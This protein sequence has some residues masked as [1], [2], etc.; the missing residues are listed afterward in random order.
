MK[1]IKYKKKKT[2]ASHFFFLLFIIHILT[3]VYTFTSLSTPINTVE[4]LSDFL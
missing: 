4:R 3:P 1:L 2:F